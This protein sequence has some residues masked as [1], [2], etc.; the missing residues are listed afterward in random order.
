[1]KGEACVMTHENKIEIEDCLEIDLVLCQSSQICV[2][3]RDK[4]RGVYSGY[5]P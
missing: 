4:R 2:E 5:V 3:G 1:M